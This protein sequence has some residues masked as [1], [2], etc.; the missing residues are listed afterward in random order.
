MIYGFIE[1]HGTKLDADGEV[2]FTWSGHAATGYIGREQLA[3]LR[4]HLNQLLGPEVIPGKKADLDGLTK[5][6][7]RAALEAG[8]WGLT[9]SD[10]I[11]SRILSAL[12]AVIHSL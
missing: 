10:T 1:V 2:M 4:A 12:E 5:G 8:T 9:S 3:H 6:E 11:D 7:M